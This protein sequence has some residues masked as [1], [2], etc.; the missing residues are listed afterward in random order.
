MDIV[1][2]LLRHRPQA[3]RVVCVDGFSI[4]VQA[5]ANHYCKPRKDA[6]Q[7]IQVECGFPSEEEAL[8]IPYAES[9]DDPC[10]TVYG[11]VPVHLVERV[12][13]RHGGAVK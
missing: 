3:P 10:H 5:S 4:S 12:I 11:Y 1:W 6:A 13:E 9:P 2:Y 7:W 8:L